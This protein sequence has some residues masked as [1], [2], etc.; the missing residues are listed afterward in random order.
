MIISNIDFKKHNKEVEEVWASFKKGQPLRIPMILGLSSR[1]FMFNEQVNPKG[2]SYKEYSE[3]P[4][5][6]FD[7]QVK[8]D[9]FRRM[10]IP[11]DYEMGIPEKGWN[12]SVDFQNYYESAWLGSSIRYIEN[13]VP[14]SEPFLSEDNKNS[15]F[16]KGIP[17][18]FSGLMGTCRDY[19]EYFLDKAKDYTFEGAKVSNITPAVL[20]T[21]GPF[22][23]ACNIRGTTDF[24]IDL[25]ED[26]DY[27][28]R[29]LEFITDATIYRLKAW[30]KYMGMP[31]ISER[32]YFAD[33]SILLLSCDQYRE[34]VLP[35]HK[36]LIEALSNN[37]VHN[38]IHLCGDATRHFQIIKEELNV[39]LFDTGF[40]VKHGELVKQLGQDVIIQGGP[41]V[42]L[43]RSGTVYEIDGEVR[44]IIGEVKD[45]TK[46][47]VLREGNNLAPHTPLENIRAMY[48]A[49]KKYSS[50]F[51]GD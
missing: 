33:D 30:R 3:N 38:C 21:D 13:N 48:E 17:D 24:C 43:L 4:D 36:K 32:L 11:A 7:M 39:K 9:Y 51:G 29:L 44:R 28:H 20:G 1:Y 34:Y 14:S 31:E 6:M 10:N 16:V 25:Y 41:H 35:Y 26:P 5:I 8:S 37:S 2:I 12:I 18:A 45:Y 22:T 46:K 40:P 27:A 42:E 50:Y 15:I 23:I 47:F 49:C 19:Y